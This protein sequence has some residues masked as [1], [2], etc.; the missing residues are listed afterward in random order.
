MPVNST[1]LKISELSLRKSRSAYYS[2]AFVA[3]VKSAEALN[4]GIG[5]WRWGKLSEEEEQA[6]AW[7]QSGSPI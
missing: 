1:H 7:V 4:V 6:A 2:M 5:G 3:N